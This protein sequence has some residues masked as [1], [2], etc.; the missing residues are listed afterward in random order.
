MQKKLTAYLRGA[1]GTDIEFFGECRR[2]ALQFERDA[3][4]ALDAYRKLDEDTNNPRAKERLA[5]LEADLTAA[6]N[7]TARAIEKYEEAANAL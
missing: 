2:R 5:R 6:K 1:V 3:A 4:Q 7:D